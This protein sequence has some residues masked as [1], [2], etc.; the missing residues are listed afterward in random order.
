MDPYLYS[1]SHSENEMFSSRDKLLLSWAL[2]HREVPGRQLRCRSA[3]GQPHKGWGLNPGPRDTSK[4]QGTSLCGAG[5]CGNGQGMKAAGR[6]SG[7]VS[8]L[9]I[10]VKF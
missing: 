1:L 6:E 9:S 10:T 5:Q 8:F 3:S 7:L 2:H 4:A